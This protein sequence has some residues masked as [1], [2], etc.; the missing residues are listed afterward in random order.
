MRKCFEWP[1]RHWFA[2]HGS[3]KPVR[4]R[5]LF[6]SILRTGI[7]VIFGSLG[8]RAAPVFATPQGRPS[9]YECNQNIRGGGGTLHVNGFTIKI[10]AKPKEM[11]CGATIQSPRG[12]IVFEYDDWGID[13]LPV[14]GKDVNGDG[15]PDAVL[16]GYS[17]GAHCCWTYSIISL[18]EKPG[19]ISDFEN[20]DNASF[21]DL[22][23][24]GRIEILVRDSDFD[25]FEDLAHAFAPFPLLILRLEGNRFKDVGSEFLGTY[26]KEI[27][28]WRDKLS[29][30]SLD[31]FLHPSSAKPY[32][33]VDYLDTKSRVLMVVLDYLYSGRSKEAWKSLDE[34]WPAE[35]KERIRDKILQRYCN[36]LRTSLRLGASPVCK[37]SPNLV[38]F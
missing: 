11:V 33:E 17:G 26:D 36:G 38:F 3:S 21:Q 16:E 19:L 10:E 22:N 6:T 18:G 8:V 24:D 31:K 37:S 7:L 25:Y 9:P 23:G 1:L 27:G 4:V 13:I 34:L 2:I 32:D 5:L 15:Q 20:G 29:P 35:D 28:A 12:D 14:T 30:S